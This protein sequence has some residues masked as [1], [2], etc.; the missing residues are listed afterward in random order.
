M[1]SA[2]EHL[3]PV[4]LELGG[5]SPTIVHFDADIQLAARRIMWGRLINAGQTCIAPDYVLVHTKIK[6]AFVDAC[7]KQVELFYG[8]DIQK[9]HDYARII[10][11]RHLARLK[12]IIDAHR[13]DI[14]CGGQVDENERFIAPTILTNVK[15]D[16]P[17]MKEEIFGPILPILEYD[18]LDKAIEFINSRPKPLALYCFTSDDSVSEAVIHKTS[19]GGVSINDSLMHFCNPY[20]PF[21]GIGTSGV[22]AYHGKAGFATFS[23][24]KP[25][26]E[27]SRYLDAFIRYPPYTDF[28]YSVFRYAAS[29][30]QIN[31]DSFKRLF[32]T[33]FLPLIAG[34]AAHRC[35]ITIGF[36]SRL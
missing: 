10:N 8:K 35:G 6:K 21:G 4:T 27:K 17:A 3:T 36:R 14:V 30:Y 18:A 31:S 32:K 16:S 22:G 24:P 1:K 7:V 5:K 9:N 25:I 28:N 2:A 12:S 13:S 26:L 33:V 20:L 34:V 11:A 23:H 19:S 29:I 15:P